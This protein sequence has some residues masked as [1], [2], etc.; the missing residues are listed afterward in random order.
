MDNCYTP[1]NMPPRESKSLKLVGML[2][3][4]LA[5]AGCPG[6][7]SGG[8]VTTTQAPGSDGGGGSGGSVSLTVDSVYPSTSGSS[9]TPITDG[10]GMIYAK[11][12]SLTMTGTCSRGVGTIQLSESSTLFPTNS[13]ACDATGAWT[14]TYT[15][16]AGSQANYT[17]VATPVTGDGTANTSGAVSKIVRV[18]DSS[19][20]PPTITAPSAS[21]SYTQTSSNLITISGT[22]PADMVRIMGPGGADSSTGS[23]GLSLNSGNFSMNV[24]LTSGA[25]TAFSFYGYDKA[26][27]ISAS[28][29]INISYIPSIALLIAGAVPGGAN[30]TGTGG[31]SAEVSVLP[32][33]RSSTD[34]GTGYISYLGFNLLV[35]QKRVDP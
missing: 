21:G 13:V 20:N 9:W 14:W 29:T 26:G 19:P 12:T 15:F 31:Y 11:G 4:V 28:G 10:T 32:V 3:F 34:G 7:G 5:L 1:K 16:A 23:G 22:V 33:N 27:N 25:S 35:N 2:T 30:V 18:D 8:D 6:G 17:I 24:T